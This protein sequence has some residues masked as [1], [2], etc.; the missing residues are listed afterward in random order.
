[1]IGFGLASRCPSPCP[2]ISVRTRTRISKT[3]AKTKTKTNQDPSDSPNP[4]QPEPAKQAKQSKVESREGATATAEQSRSRRAGRGSHLAFCISRFA[5][6]GCPA[7]Q[8]QSKARQGK[9]RLVSHGQHQF[10]QTNRTRCRI[11]MTGP[12]SFGDSSPRHAR[13]GSGSS[14]VPDPY[15]ARVGSGIGI[16]ISGWHGTATRV[17]RRVDREDQNRRWYMRYMR[18]M[19]YKLCKVRRQSTSWS[20]TEAQLSSRREQGYALPRSLLFRSIP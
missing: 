6:T 14:Q 9:A 5:P 11:S 17:E 4:N 18:Y 8:A 16:G 13:S 19:R 20:R 15:G 3:K 7:R 1:M 10:F 12:F 2:S